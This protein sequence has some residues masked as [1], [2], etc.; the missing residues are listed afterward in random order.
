VAGQNSVRPRAS[1]STLKEVQNAGHRRRRKAAH[2]SAIVATGGL[3][4][5]FIVGRGS[6]MSANYM[7]FALQLCYR[8]PL[9]PPRPIYRRRSR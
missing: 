3:L 8:T 7:S 6:L 5:S 1:V 9:T 4:F 2:R